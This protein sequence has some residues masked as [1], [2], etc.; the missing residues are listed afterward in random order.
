M[1]TTDYTSVP[2]GLYRVAIKEINTDL[3]RNGHPR[4][5]LRLV[6]AEGEFT[7]RTAA[8]DTVVMSERGGYRHSIIAAA[9]NLEP[10]A[11]VTEYL[12][13]EAMVTIRHEEHES[14]VGDGVV[15]RGAVP[16]AGWG[17]V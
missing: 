14:A 11:P 1:S 5:T 9:L 3:T 6:V 4:H 7:G 16:Y 13:L 2:P 8:W 17:K 15:I 10:E 12:G